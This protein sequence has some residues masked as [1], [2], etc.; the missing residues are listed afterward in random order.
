M[1]LDPKSLKWIHQGH[2]DTISE[3]PWSWNPR[4]VVG[5]ETDRFDLPSD[6]FLVGDQ[7]NEQVAHEIR[8]TEAFP[9]TCLTSTSGW[10]PSPDMEFVDLFLET[11]DVGQIRAI[12]PVQ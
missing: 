9:R 8:K 6:V 4:V 11:T 2:F 5:L 10:S 7:D 1:F 12:F 3:C